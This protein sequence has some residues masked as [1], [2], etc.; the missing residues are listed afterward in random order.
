MKPYVGSCVA[1]WSRIVLTLLL[2]PAG[3]SLGQPAEPL[4]AVPPPVQVPALLRL[5]DAIRIAL[6]GST[7]LGIGQARIDVSRKARTNA[8]FSLGPD[9]SGSWFNQRAT[10]TDLAFTADVEQ[11]VPTA[12]DGIVAVSGDTLQ[13]VTAR[14]TITAPTNFPESTEESD[15]RQ[16][17]LT[18]SVRLFDGLANYYRI[19]AAGND[20]RADE[21]SKQFTSTDVQTNVIEAYYNLLRATLLLRVAQEAVQVA[22]DQLQRTQALYELGSAARSDVL[23]SQVQLGQNRLILVQARNG[24]RQAHDILVYTMNLLSATPFQI[25]TTVATIPQEDFDFQG[26]LGYAREHRLDIQALREREKAEG[27]RVVVA[28]GAL[29]PFVDFQYGLTWSDN[30]SQFRFGAPRTDTRSWTIRAGWDLWDRYQNYLNIGQAKANRRIAEYT[31]RQ[32]ELDAITE[33]RLYIN[34]LQEARERSQVTRENTERSREDLRLAQE[35][36]RVGAGTILDVTTAQQD[37]TST[38]A[39]EVQAVVDYLIARAKL[40]R[41]TGRAFAE[42]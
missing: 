11:T 1:R 9:L 34:N 26:E 13:V 42:N 23:K 25:D 4:P 27:K 37:L 12:F 7:R 3:A 6:E 10:R 33:I 8:W 30:Q 32:A 19:A 14:D 28:R 24:E 15:F 20:V 35:K 29:F 2:L 17:N 38:Q 21:L 40:S 22:T 41:A 31:R 39:A 16:F 5:S 18:S 36:F